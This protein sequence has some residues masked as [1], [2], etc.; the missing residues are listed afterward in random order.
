MILFSWNANGLGAKPKRMILK[1]HISKLDPWFLLIQE[2]KLEHLLPTTLSYLWNSP[3]SLHCLS[4][5]VGNSGGL[6][7]LWKTQHF[8]LESS[9]THRNWIALKGTLCAL[10]FKCIIINIYNPCCS[11]L[12]AGVWQELID[13]YSDSPSPIL[14][15]GDFNEVLSPMDRGSQSLDTNGVDDFRNFIQA[16]HLIEIPAADGHFTWFRG[17]SKSKLDRLFIQA[18]WLS[19][20]PL[21]Q[22]SLLQRSL[23]DHSPLLVTSQ[24]SDWGPRPFRFLDCWLTHDECME[25]IKSAWDKS[26]EKPVI[27]K[28]QSVKNDL[29]TWNVNVFGNID[30]NIQRLESKIHSWDSEAQYRVLLDSEIQDRNEAQADLWSW[31]KRKELFW[32]QHSREQWLKYGDKNSKYFHVVAS[33]RRQRNSLYSI[34]YL[35][36]NLTKP[37]EIKTAAVKFY[38]N[39]F[40]EEFRSR[41]TIDNLD[42]NRLSPSQSDFLIAPFEID[43]INRAVDSCNPSK[44]PGPDGFNFRFIKASW[45]IIKDDI[46][47]LV[48]EFWSTS[49]LPKGSNVTFITLIAKIDHPVE[50]KDYRPISMVGSIYK[51]I[52]KLLSL[53][54]K[55]VMNDII[56][57]F[58]SAFIEGRQIL[59]GALIAGE[60]FESCKRK[61]LKAVVLKLDFHKAFDCVSWNFLDWVLTQMGFPSMW[62]KW[63]SSCISS[64]SASILINGT[65]TVPFRL[66]R[67]LRQGDPLSPLLFVIA[68]EALNRLIIKATK[69]SLWEGIRIS[70][71][72]PPL[73]HL[74]YADDTIMFC[75]PDIHSLVNIKK[76]LIIFQLI[77]GLQINFHKSSIMGINIENCWLL[78]AAETLHCKVGHFPI[79][80][81]G[82]PVGGNSSRIITWDPIIER[83]RQKLASWKGNLLSLGGRLTLIKATL[84]SLPLYFMSIFPVPS[85]VIDKITSIQR[86]FLWAKGQGNTSLPLVRW[87]VLQLPKNWGGLNISNLLFRNLG[88]LFK[89]LWRYNLEPKA[90]WRTVI[91]SKYRYPHNYSLADLSHIKCGGPWKKICNTLLSNPKASSLLKNGLRKSVGDGSDTLFW[92]ETWLHEKPLKIACPRLFRIS[93]LQNA[94]VNEM[95]CWRNGVW[96]WSLTWA[97]PFRAQD[98]IE[99]AYLQ[100]LLQKVVLLPEK[101]DRLIWA[102]HKSGDYSVK[103]FYLEMASSLSSSPAAKCYRKLWK[104]LVPPRIEIFTWIACLEKLNTRN[105]LSKLNIIP[106]HEDVCILCKASTE[107]GPHLLL[108]CQFSWILW[109]WWCNIWSISWVCP[110]SIQLA[111]EQWFL[112]SKSEI[113]RK[114]W[115]AG[116]MVIVWSI[117][118]ERNARIFTNKSCSINEIKDLIL[119]RLSWW[120]K[121][122]NDPL[123]FSLENIRKNPSCLLTSKNSLSLKPP[124]ETIHWSPPEPSQ[125]KWN[126]DASLSPSLGRSAIGGV[127]RGPDGLFKCLF[128]CPIPPMEINSAEVLAIHRAIQISLNNQEFKTSKIIIESDSQNAVRWCTSQKGGPWHLNFILNFIRS[129]PARG[130]EISIHHKRRNANF[131]AD[132]LAKQGLNRGS[133]F[134]AWV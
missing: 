15:I 32:S 21:L 55:K 24:P 85:G 43:E 51:I 64:A 14:I 22:V 82:L 107:S 89:W 131:V 129:A 33:I 65:P 75:H 42:F 76:T 100:N 11:S 25:V 49:S 17:S 47:K 109:S 74:Q 41:P 79:S 62:R 117:W 133:D 101:K 91:Q 30:S 18:E 63:I 5:S 68:A 4:P 67:G 128:S 113:S 126:V 102:P 34:R 78:S 37:D 52:A 36:S 118:K 96:Y 80:Y 114:L 28:L 73:T 31:L 104:G 60:L 87:D 99:W 92:L 112:P 97:R 45:S 124:P 38:K 58:Q 27:Q 95:G 44:A 61:N 111:L 134:V 122:W 121:N 106:P 125:I 16:L 81:L 9:S 77:S 6:L 69:A 26:K 70:K 98:E 23:S 57:P 39:L 93:P 1:K 120:I 105:K 94:H 54:L 48:N 59:D 132:S 83:L 130:L 90:L 3:N 110:S 86:N 7:S 40:S 123:P 56:G 20:F 12:R 53:R 103:S 50:F 88:L 119:L 29:K 10:N 46:Y 108:H 84:S 13:H 72:S 71:E 127:L 2:T 116:F 115:L 8:K 35:G 66:Q 19:L